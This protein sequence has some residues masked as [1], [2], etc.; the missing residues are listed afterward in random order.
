MCVCVHD[1][2]MCARGH[3]ARPG[4][5]SPPTHIAHLPPPNCPPP[6]AARPVT[7]PKTWAWSYKGIMG[8]KRAMGSTDDI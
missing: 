5:V 2:C 7:M 3:L 8:P 4:E 1:V 6:E